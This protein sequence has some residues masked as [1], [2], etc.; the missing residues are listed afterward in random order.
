MV[1]DRRIQRLTLTLLLVLGGAGLAPVLASEVPP[2]SQ[3]TAQSGLT[4]RVLGE[5]APLASVRV[6]AFQLRDSSLMKAVTDAGGRFRFDALPAGLYKIVAH[7]VGFAPA[8]IMLRRGRSDSPQFLELQLTQA[9]NEEASAE[10][11]FWAVREEIPADILRE[12]EGPGE[13]LR[14]ALMATPTVLERPFSAQ[15]EAMTGF[16]QTATVSGARVSGGQLGVAGTIGRVRL[17]VEGDYWQFAPAEAFHA[18]RAVVDG[19]ASNLSV[20]LETAERARFGL[21]SSNQRLVA[22][23]DSPLD[24]DRY[25]ASWTQPLGSDREAQVTADFTRQTNVYGRGLAEFGL[26][27]ASSQTWA[28]EGT[29]R[30]ELGERT[31]FETGFRYRD[32]IVGVGPGEIAL[33]PRAE[34]SNRLDL[35]GRAGHRVQPRILVEYGFFST[36]HDGSVSLAPQ[37]GLVVQLND[38]WQAS[39]LFSHRLTPESADANAPGDFVTA[40]YGANGDCNQGEHSCY[41]VLLTKNV[42]GLE[43]FSIGAVQRTIGDTQQVLFDAQN[44]LGAPDS[45]YFVEGD[46]I[47]EVQVAVQRELAPQIVAKL[48]GNV[49]A[50]GGGILLGAHNRPYENSVRYL[51]TSL[52]TRFEGSQTGVF[53]SFYRL[54]QEL[55]PV[56]SVVLSRAGAAPRGELERLQMMLT[57]DLDSILNLA[58]NWAIK[59][60][61]ELTRGSALAN[62]SVVAR[63]EL[64]KKILGGLAIRF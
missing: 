35:F 43:A 5:I 24:F 57:Q 41:S 16:D 10:D 12:I 26:L 21:R 45:L 4:G 15:M 34:S 39:T 8:V 52:D 1:P 2:P 28:V 22:A 62:S 13:T 42:D 29:Y 61:M 58:S 3:P 51:V 48:E 18:P 40:L 14:V 27:P 56:G 20:Q 32:R 60:D 50:G 64:R 54:E 30:H 63:D 46:R 55:T 53:L 7:K 38:S 17:G 44:F 25:E 33:D 47:P 59:L 11:G 9:A 49:G 23:G 6:W 31:G 36:L 37:G 19:E